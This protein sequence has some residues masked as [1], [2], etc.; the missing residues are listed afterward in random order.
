MRQCPGC[1]KQKRADNCIQCF[2]TE[3][4]RKE[5]LIRDIKEIA[6]NTP[7]MSIQGELLDY[8]NHEGIS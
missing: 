5:R 6:H 3:K 8:L 1:M 2:V 4:E 7:F